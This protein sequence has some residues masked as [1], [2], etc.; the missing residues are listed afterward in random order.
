MS[1]FTVF[2]SAHIIG[3]VLILIYLFRQFFLPKLLPGIPHNK[4]VT[5]RLF[6]DL[7]EMLA[8]A[9]EHGEYFTWLAQQNRR[10]ESPVVQVF[11]RPFQKPWVL[12]A[13]YRE[14]RDIMTRRTKEF[15]RSR[16]NGEILG[17]LLPDAHPHMRSQS[18]EFKRNK[19]LI[20][21]LMTSKFLNEV[22]SHHIYACISTMVKL[23]RTKMK[24][25]QSRPFPA[26]SD[27]FNGTLDAAFAS[28]F[29]L[30]EKDSSTSKQL[31]LLLSQTDS[32][33]LPASVND[34]ARFPQAS[35]PQDFEAILTLTDLNDITIKFPIP[36]LAFWV[37]SKT[38]R[39]C[40][41]LRL[42]EDLIERGINAAEERLQ[43]GQ[44]TNRS[45]IDDILYHEQKVA[46]KE[47]RSPDYYS[48][49]IRDEIFA[50]IIAG[51]DTTAATMSWGVKYLSD[52]T[53]AQNRLRGE[54]HKAYSQAV[55]EDREPSVA[56]ITGTPIAYL[57]ACLEEIIRVSV[58]GGGVVR[59]ALVDTQ[60]LGFN[61]PKG[62]E[63]FCVPNG[64]GI[65]TP[66]IKVDE[67]Q[68]SRTA[69]YG[70][71]PKIREW[72]VDDMDEFQPERWLRK[73]E[74]SGEWIY[75]SRA[76]PTL[77]FGLG[78]RACFGR[79]MAYLELRIMVVLFL[80]NFVLESCGQELSSYDTTQR[81][82]RQ[83]RQCYIKLS[84]A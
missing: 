24:I 34:P 42:K 25:G 60:L 55:S 63:V 28:T 70:K 15:D 82:S 39:F 1:A 22:E 64:P 19:S 8:Y 37:I 4:H 18:A 58:V 71:S 49:H 62:T 50:F 32:I 26:N 78:P 48:R 54:L 51:H 68:R 44:K 72:S 47:H 46:E 5:S 23:W 75:D 36:R 6:G 59:Q 31:N 29:G 13:D 16:F 27:I 80:W 10:L 66:P 12:L 73:D 20:D 65:F 40:R 76:G 9:K 77:S 7:S 45:A 2:P 84:P 43:T 67:E 17:G 53:Q 52:N 14:S 81:L 41:A 69:R 79:A 30:D 57:D 61:I 11:I 83:P 38:R 3:I 35:R 33:R 56:E 21:N 74:S